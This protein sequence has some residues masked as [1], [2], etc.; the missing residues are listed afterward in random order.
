[1]VSRKESENSLTWK[2]FLEQKKDEIKNFFGW[3]LIIGLVLAII[4]VIVFVNWILVTSIFGPELGDICGNISPCIVGYAGLIAFF[5]FVEMII[6][7]WLSDNWFKARAKA[8][9][10]L[11]GR[12]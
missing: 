4:A 11:G 3:I 7:L 2:F 12:E 5:I 8:R 9:R 6:F 1:M 10:Q